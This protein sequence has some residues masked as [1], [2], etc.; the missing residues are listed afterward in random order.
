MFSMATQFAANCCDASLASVSISLWYDSVG[1]RCQYCIHT[2]GPPLMLLLVE[3]ESSQGQI[4]DRRPLSESKSFERL[5]ERDCQRFFLDFRSYGCSEAFVMEGEGHKCNVGC[6]VPLY[7]SICSQM[8]LCT[9]L[10]S[11]FDAPAQTGFLWIH[12]ARLNQQETP[13]CVFRTLAQESSRNSIA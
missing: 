8:K 10:L 11:S 13:F 6:K 1:W 12:P 9:G 2:F 7:L 4:L 3:F 5:C